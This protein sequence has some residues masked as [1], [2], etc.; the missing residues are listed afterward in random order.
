MLIKGSAR[1]D[2]AGLARHLEKEEN[3]AVW[4]VGSKDVAAQD[5]EGAL[6]EMDAL[7]AALRT[8]RTLYHMSINPV[9]GKDRLMSA[10]E[11]DYSCAA[12][13]K[14]MGLE[15]QPHLIVGHKKIGKD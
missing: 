13:L 14:K 7:G 11:W 9:P 15:D 10:E 12:A 1:G 8:H 4:I 2:A 3:E 6:L 5:I